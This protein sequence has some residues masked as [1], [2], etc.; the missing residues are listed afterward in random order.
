MKFPIRTLFAL[1]SSAF[2]LLIALPATASTV[3]FGE[4]YTLPTASRVERNLY[5][6]AGTALVSSP[7]DGDVTVGAGNATV[8][9]PVTGDILITGGTLDV[10]GSVGGDL[11][12]AGGILTISDKIGGDAVLAGGSVSLLSGASVAGDALV[13]GGKVSLLGTI[14]GTTYVAGGDIFIDGNIKG[15]VHI[16]SA[17][18]VRVGPHAVIGGDFMYRASSNVVIDPAAVIVGKTTFQYIP[19]MIS[20][21]DIRGFFAGLFG[22]LFVTRLLVLMVSALFFVLVFRRGTSSLVGVSLSTFWKMC[23]IGLAIF[24]AVPFAGLIIG[25]TI[26]GGLLAIVMLVVWLVLLLI[27]QIYA[28]VVFAAVC[29]KYIFKQEASPLVSWRT[30]ALGVL[31]LGVVCLVP[32]V[33]LFI[34]LVFFLVALGSLSTLAYRHF[35]LSR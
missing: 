3:G 26:F 18:R 35:I 2:V 6:A 13:A 11:R 15:T 27:A 19:P 7:V 34:G 30:A 17:G 28:G 16:Y 4:T 21:H 9:G 22:L 5:V 31:G 8:S 10:L 20:A 25:L 29:Q 23:L 12:G 33:G 14:D 1:L 32:Y 24:V